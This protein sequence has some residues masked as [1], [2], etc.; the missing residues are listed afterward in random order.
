MASR[1]YIVLVLMSLCAQGQECPHTNSYVIPSLVEIRWLAMPDSHNGGPCVIQTAMISA[2][3]GMNR[4]SGNSFIRLF[5]NF[6]EQEV[7]DINITI[8]PNFWTTGW[9]RLLLVTLLMSG[10]YGIYRY[11]MHWLRLRQKQEFAL[12]IRVQE[13]ERQRFAKE[14]HDGVGANL[15]ILQMYLNSLGTPA[16]P[17]EELRARSIAIL[18]TSLDDIRSIIHDLHPCSLGQAGL[19]QT[20]YE[21]VAHLNDSNRLQVQFRTE[22]VPV[23]L[24]ERIEI[25]LFRIIQELLQ[26]ALKHANASN[27]WL[28]LSKSDNTLQLTYQ[29]NGCGLDQSFTN[30]TLGNGLL[31][32]R[33]RIDLLKGTHQFKLAE[34]NGTVVKIVV[35]LPAI[36]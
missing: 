21:L 20:V 12:S 19:E 32:I 25:N 6:Q 30:E 23:R 10:L 18:K 31:N 5:T 28:Q 35:P 1:S 2:D 36:E 14:L 15:A 17:I 9:V 7:S 22:D 33:Q 34:P 3:G 16:I 27:V 29:D 13:L 24:P 8:R 11:R 26:N 4:L